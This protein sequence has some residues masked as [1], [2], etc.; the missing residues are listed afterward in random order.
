MDDSGTSEPQT[1]TRSAA[2]ARL[3]GYAGLAPFIALS[4]WLYGIAPDHEWRNGTILLLL[5][6]GAV[7]L[8]FLG[9]VRWG[10]ALARQNDDARL[11]FSLAMLPPLIGWI[12]VFIPVPYA[13][14]VLAVAFAAQGAWDT[15][16]VHAEKAPEWY[17]ELRTILTI[18]VVLTLIVA[19]IATS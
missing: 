7:I 11:D 5:V 3:L 9:G 13:F 19:F 10:V 17:G 6:Y 18:I 14:A 1:V 12:A 15:L 2:M 4:L 16:A 8:S